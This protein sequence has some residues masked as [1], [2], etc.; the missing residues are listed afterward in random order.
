MCSRYELTESPEA[1]SARFGIRLS[2]G[3]EI[4]GVVRPTDRGLLVGPNRTVGRRSWGIAASWASR[5]LTNARLESLAE[6]PTFRPLLNRRVAVPVNHW[7]E[8]QR[9]EGLSGR[10][11]WRMARADLGVMALAAL[12]DGVNFIIVTREALGALS[13]AHERMPVILD[14]DGL[15]AWLDSDDDFAGIRAAADC[16]SRLCA[17][18]MTAVPDQAPPPQVDLFD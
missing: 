7:W 1:L 12:T 6:K 18:K 13:Q 17:E 8:W 10:R 2:A 14:E 5:P 4:A 3:L 9:G 11:L 16:S 15:A